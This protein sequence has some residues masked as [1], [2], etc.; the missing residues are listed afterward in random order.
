MAIYLSHLAWCGVSHL[1]LTQ[2]G[3]AAL[4]H[5][6]WQVVWGQDWEGQWS[7]AAVEGKSGSN[8]TAD[9]HV[10]GLSAAEKLEILNS[11]LFIPESGCC[12]SLHSSQISSHL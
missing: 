10:R 12:R 9:N 11:I 7:P 2:V 8:M 4:G 3:Q 5:L 6:T 1:L